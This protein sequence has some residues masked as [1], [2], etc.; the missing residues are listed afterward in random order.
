MYGT[1]YF[2]RVKGER[3]DEKL[4]SMKWMAPESLEEDIFTEATD[5]VSQKWANV[6][7]GINH[8]ANIV[9]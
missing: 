1:Y 2:R 6:I 3:E 4:L 7:L 5:M 9:E 8:H